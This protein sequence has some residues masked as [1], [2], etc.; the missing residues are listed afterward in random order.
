MTYEEQLRALKKSTAFVPF[1]VTTKSGD[2]YEVRDWLHF[3]LSLS[4][5]HCAVSADRL[6]SFPIAEIA[7]V[8]AMGAI[9]G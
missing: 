5:F 2:R 7:S 1:R 3:A 6:V 4:Q 8:E 9:A